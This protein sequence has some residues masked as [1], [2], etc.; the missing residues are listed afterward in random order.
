MESTFL[1]SLNYSVSVIKCNGCCESI[2]GGV[3]I[4]IW[5]C[6]CTEPECAVCLCVCVCFMC[7]IKTEYE[8]K[9]TLCVRSQ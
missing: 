1:I 2:K 3:N 4:F 7:D 9:T 6:E 8:Q 5:M